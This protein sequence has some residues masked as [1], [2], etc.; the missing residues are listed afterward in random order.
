MRLKVSH[1][2]EYRYDQP[3]GYGLQRLRL[4][5][6]DAKTQSVINWSIDIEGRAEEE[7]RYMP[8]HLA[9]IRGWSRSTARR[10]WSHSRIWRG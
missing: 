2:T 3:M 8:T 9:M 5:P 4:K 10:M 6:S 7:L 1:R